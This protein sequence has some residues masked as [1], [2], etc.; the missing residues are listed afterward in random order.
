MSSEQPIV[1]HDTCILL[2]LVELNLLKE[3]F[4][5]GFAAFTTPLVMAEIRDET[6]LSIIEE[7]VTSGALLIDDSGSIE[8]IY[9][10]LD[11]NKG[12][13]FADCSV[14]ELGLRKQGT[15]LSSDRGLR[16]CC[17]RDGL[18]VHGM[19]WIIESLH[20]AGIIH[21]DYACSCLKTY[22][23]INAW[24]PKVEIAILIETIKSYSN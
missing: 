15:I 14:Y 21:H 11:A 23:S 2:D 22:S 3:F 10:I 12:L 20:S 18:H 1:I 17:E 19:L 5:L 4:Q 8:S 7:H 6:Q 13:T 24:A 16:K 9:L